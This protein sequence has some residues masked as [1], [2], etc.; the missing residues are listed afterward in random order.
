MLCVFREFSIFYVVKNRFNE[1]SKV[2]GKLL[3]QVARPMRNHMGINVA[4]PA[5]IVPA[6]IGHKGDVVN[7]L[8][9]ATCCRIKFQNERSMT[10]H[11]EYFRCVTL[12]GEMQSAFRCLQLFGSIIQELCRHDGGRVIPYCDS[13][14]GLYLDQ[15]EQQSLTKA[16]LDEHNTMF[17]N[18]IEIAIDKKCSE[19]FRVRVDFCGNCVQE[20]ITQACALLLGKAMR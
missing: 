15:T 16:W 11:G 3:E 18:K 12:T 14:F 17:K 5:D 19:H 20:K 9:A 6:L 8:E 13:Y 10:N 1:I 7:E 4:I 2:C